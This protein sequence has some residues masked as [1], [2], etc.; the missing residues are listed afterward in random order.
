MVSTLHNEPKG[1]GWIADSDEAR[2]DRPFGGSG[3]LG[4]PKSCP[5]QAHSGRFPRIP[6]HLD[7][8][9]SPLLSKVLRAL[10]RPGHQA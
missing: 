2:R 8:M 9:D 1:V 7:A 10:P 3:I 6:A 5:S 4:V